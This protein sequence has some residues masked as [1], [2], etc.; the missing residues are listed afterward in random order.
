KQEY[1]AAVS[2]INS[3]NSL[4]ASRVYDAK[5]VTIG[6]K[7]LALAPDDTVRAQ[8]D[9]PVR[10]MTSLPK[11]LETPQELFASIDGGA[12]TNYSAAS[13]KQIIRDKCGIAG[14]APSDIQVRC[15]GV[16]VNLSV[17]VFDQEDRAYALATGIYYLLPQ[18]SMVKPRFTTARSIARTILGLA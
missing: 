15:V 13:I 17:L 12:P 8:L 9:I 16:C 6:D 11:G 10:V 2:L 18:L 7:V 4:N 3:A 14:Y 1:T 5:L